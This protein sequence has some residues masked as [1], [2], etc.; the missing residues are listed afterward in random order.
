[1]ISARQIYTGFRHPSLIFRFLN[2]KLRYGSGNEQGIHV[3]DEDWDNLIILDA[4]RYDYFTSTVA[5]ELGGELQKRQSRG[6]ATPE[7]V[8][9]NFCGRELHDT[10]YVS[11]NGWYH[12][13]Q[14]E[15]GGSLHDARWL[16]S[17]EYRNAIGT[18]PP[19]TVT[20]EAIETADSYPHKRLLVH[21][22]QPH[23]PYLGPT[24]EEYFE[25][26]RGINMVELMKQ[27]EGAT[28]ETLRK[29]YRENLEA[30]L[31]PLIE[32][33]DALAGKTVVSADHGELLGE[34]YFSLPLRNYGHPAGVHLPELVDI[35]WFVHHHTERK[36][37]VD[38]PPVHQ[39]DADTDEVEEHLRLLG[40]V[41]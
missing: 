5:P 18:V 19:D 11:A 14:G 7:W 31:P 15:I 28:V 3:F 12:Q 36:S 30:T 22:V 2:R 29:A 9:E 10:V 25:N 21:F 26:A 41:A 39:D 1:M 34:R 6:S 27:A 32:L 20:R 23:K 13:L 37:I 40:Y 38:E 24:G 33:L 16:Y 4:C 8:R 35:P 17:D